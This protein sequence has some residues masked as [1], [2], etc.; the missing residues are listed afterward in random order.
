[1]RFLKFGSALLVSGVLALLVAPTV[2]SS[3]AS[4]STCDNQFIWTV[5]DRAAT[6][7]N[8]LG[9]M[10]KWSTDGALLDSFEFNSY[11]RFTGDISLSADGKHIYGI[12]DSYDSNGF[13]AGPGYHDVLDSFSAIGPSNLA[14]LD[15]ADTTLTGGRIGPEEDYESTVNNVASNTRLEAS[16]LVDNWANE[17]GYYWARGG[18]V[19][20]E[21]N[22]IIDKDY[23][24]GQL[25][26]IDLA[27]GRTAS[28][29]INLHDADAS[30]EDAGQTAGIP[31]RDQTSFNAWGLGGDVF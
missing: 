12:T 1:M 17:V 15:A 7:E 27:N 22:M 31:I 24:S 26:K 18:A 6:F 9:V 5:D 29:W 28:N 19:I 21:N 14:S 3:P 8:P 16:W 4:G 2:S 25:L 20:S 13:W 10:Q 23:A 30:L 11:R